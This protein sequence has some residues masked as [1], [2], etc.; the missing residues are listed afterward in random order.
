MLRTLY[1]T[2]FVVLSAIAGFFYYSQTRLVPAVVATT[3]LKVG[4]Q[5]EDA[6]VTIRRVNP[7]AVPA[8]TLTRTDQAVGRVVSFPILQGQFID[9]R[10]VAPGRNA[11]LLQS[12]LH[13][14]KGFRIISLPI[15][16]AAAVGGALK[17]GDL[18]DVIAVPNAVRSSG[19][20]EEPGVPSIIGKRIL[21]LGIRNEQGTELD[22]K[23]FG[24]G[25]TV[26]TNKANSILL[27]IPAIDETRYSSAIATSTFF[28]ALTTD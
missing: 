15:V 11:E 19:M 25:I 10:Q 5:V 13:V 8:G 12:G 9:P 21:V 26:A 24:K 14:P 17:A 28:F 3:T 22:Q 2:A 18:V 20:P 6:D 27:A 7:S 16:P 1:L 23:G 4:A